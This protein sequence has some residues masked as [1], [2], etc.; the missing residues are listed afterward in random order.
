LNDR[1]TIDLLRWSFYQ[2]KRRAAAGIEAHMGSV[3]S[4]F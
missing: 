2:L 4:G 1:D 3:R